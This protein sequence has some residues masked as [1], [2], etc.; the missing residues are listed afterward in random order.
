MKRKYK[1]IFSRI[2]RID[3]FGG[4]EIF[5]VMVDKIEFH[6]FFLFFDFLFLG[7]LID[8][9]WFTFGQCA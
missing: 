9:L 7:L 2:L 3:M 6:S 5:I 4:I 1:Y 8:D